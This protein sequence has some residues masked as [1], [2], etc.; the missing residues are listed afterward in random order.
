MKYQQ[1]IHINND[2]YHLMHDTTNPLKLQTG[3]WVSLYGSRPSRWVGLVGNGSTVW[4]T[5]FDGVSN[6]RAKFGM[7]C[8]TFRCR[9]RAKTPEEAAK[10]EVLQVKFLSQ[11]K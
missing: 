5:H 1:T 2:N 4:L 7:L 11:F 3:Q 6:N 10:F 8:L 9:G